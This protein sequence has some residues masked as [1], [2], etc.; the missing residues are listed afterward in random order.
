MLADFYHLAVNG[1]DVSAAVTAQAADFGHIQIADDPGR[2]QPGSGT[3]P[4]DE[5]LAA[6]HAGGYDGYVGLEYKDSSSDPFGWF[7]RDQRAS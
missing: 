2:G 7:P 6:A 1:D 3:L 4:L 5:W